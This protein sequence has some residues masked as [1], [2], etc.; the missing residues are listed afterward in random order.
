[1]SE[2]NVLLKK[3]I[4]NSSDGLINLKQIGSI[5]IIV[6]SPKKVRARLTSK[7]ML[8]GVPYVVTVQATSPNVISGE[9]WS[10]KT[11][12]VGQD[13]PTNTNDA[14][15]TGF[16]LVS[17]VGLEVSAA[18]SPPNAEIITKL[19]IDPGPSNPTEI[20]IVAPMNFQFPN[21]TDCLAEPNPD[22]KACSPKRA[23]KNGQKTA[24]L[25]TRDQGLT[26]AI[27]VYVY[28]ITPQ[29]T[30][31]SK[32]WFVEARDFLQDQQIGWG[33]DASGFEVIQMPQSTVSY[34]G[35]NGFEVIT[36]F[37]APFW[38]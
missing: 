31:P 32:A 14:E 29:S 7:P 34:T 5:N 21:K 30:P 33:E 11:W 26:S 36:V 9:V 22:I 37:Y 17:Q 19:A 20:V 12:E 8:T 2:E 6:N 18:R 24:L 4:I 25:Q 3:T 1:M 28:V 35:P 15:Q 13:L 27:V 23:L 10:F 16:S 38:W